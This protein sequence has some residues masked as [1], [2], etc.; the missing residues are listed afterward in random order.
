MLAGRF[1]M[2]HLRWNYEKVASTRHDTLTSLRAEVDCHRPTNE[3]NVC[4]V[5]GMVMPATDV[6]RL[7]LDPATPSYPAAFAVEKIASLRTGRPRTQNWFLRV[8]DD[9]AAC[10]S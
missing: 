8:N 9:G 6:A 7:I 4:V 2:N 3:V 1:A 10:N 5:G